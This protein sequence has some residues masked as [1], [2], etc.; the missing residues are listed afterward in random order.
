MYTNIV[1]VALRTVKHNDRTSILTAWSPGYGRLSLVMPAGKGAASSARRAISMPLSLFEGVVT[2]NI[3]EGLSRIRDMKSWSPGNR[4]VDVASHPIRGAVAMFC[5]E[6][7]GTVTREGDSDEALW[8]L[9][10]ETA[11]AVSG[12]GARGLS[13]LPVMFLLRLSALL[14]IEPDTADWNDSM[15]LDMQEGLFRITKPLHDNWVDS[16]EMRH[17]I[18][19]SEAA[20]EYRHLSLPVLSR[21]VRNRILDGIIRYFV[22]HHYPLHKLRSLKVLRELFD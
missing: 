20:R 19:L 14:G 13:N 21:A 17:V 16:A 10:V 18:R 15:G 3:R 7:L 9:I 1:A 2:T 12:A 6:V 11:V 8:Q 4:R 5:A 22:L